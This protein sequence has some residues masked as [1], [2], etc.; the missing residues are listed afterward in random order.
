MEK[1]P[2]GNSYPDTLH[3][4]QL[5]TPRK[6]LVS[7]IDVPSQ[8]QAKAIKPT[9]ASST[10]ALV[11]SRHGTRGCWSINDFCDECDRIA[12]KLAAIT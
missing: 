9:L 8:Q 12:I 11:C 5:S 1:S 2:L 3:C 10:A 7:C 4:A 6:R